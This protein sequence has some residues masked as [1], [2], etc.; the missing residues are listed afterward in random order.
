MLNEQRL[1][2]MKKRLFEQLKQSVREAGKI[3]RGEMTPARVTTAATKSGTGGA[4]ELG[5]LDSRSYISRVSRVKKS[6]N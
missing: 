4:I 5:T 3:Q 2:G 1:C 6:C